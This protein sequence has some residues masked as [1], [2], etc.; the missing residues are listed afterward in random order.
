MKKVAITGIGA[1]TPL[2]NDFHSSWSKIL[3]GVSGIDIITKFDTAATLYKIAGEVKNFDPEIYLSK[4]EIL[5]LDPFIQY[6]VASSIMAIND[7]KLSEKEDLLSKAGVIIGSSRGGITTIQKELSRLLSKSCHISPYIMP[8]ST[9]SMASSYVAQKLKIR[10]YCLGISNACASGANAIG[11]AF[12]LIRNGY[13]RIILAGGSEAPICRLCLEGYGTS[14]ALSKGNSPYSC[15]PFDKKRDG[16]VIAEGA[17][18]IVLEEFESAIKRGTKIYAEI[19]GYG[20]TTD[21]FHITRPHVEGEVMAIKEALREGGIS[22]EDVDYINAHGTSTSI[23]DLVESIAIRNIF[24]NKN[25]PVSAIKSMTGHMLSASSAFEIACTA[26]SI[27]DGVIPP[28]I[29]T[30]EIDKDC[31]INLI[32]EPMK[33]VINKAISNSFGFG[34]IN[35]VIALK[36]V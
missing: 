35:A 36:R 8:S 9:I 34:G 12:R 5:R 13:Y 33:Q 25:I 2:S 24:K 1:I 22:P 16:F 28:T 3:E 32:R 7:A 27:K 18:I 20:N 11:E 31:D 29:N 21:A 17:C 14:G 15:R 26:M 6:A 19:I 30:N 4:K 10:G 23:G